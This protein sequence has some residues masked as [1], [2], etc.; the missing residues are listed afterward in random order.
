MFRWSPS[1][2]PGA[3]SVRRACRRAL[4]P[5]L[6]ARSGDRTCRV[7][8]RASCTECRCPRLCP[9]PNLSG[10]CQRVFHVQRTVE[11]TTETVY[12]GRRHPL[13]ATAIHQ[14]T[15]PHVVPLRS[16]V[17]V[18][19]HPVVIRCADDDRVTVDCLALDV[20]PV[21][22]GGHPRLYVH[23]IQ[24]ALLVG[25]A[26]HAA[27]DRPAGSFGGRERFRNGWIA[28]EPA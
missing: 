11:A 26:V 6:P 2:P 7:V 9:F 21:H 16:R 28:T 3:T 23:R 22:R 15:L 8:A 24:E 25:D 1:A 17:V 20:L 12:V 27:L 4:L 18:V 19:D 14:P 5:G 10:R 13:C